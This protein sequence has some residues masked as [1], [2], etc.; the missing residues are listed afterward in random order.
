MLDL[1]LLRFERSLLLTEVSRVICLESLKIQFI[2]VEWTFEWFSFTSVFVKN[3]FQ[4]LN[5]ICVWSG[6]YESCSLI[7]NA[8]NGT[9]TVALSFFIQTLGKILYFDKCLKIV[10]SN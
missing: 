3:I 5:N 4:Q 2:C 10:P 6:K 8:K 9:I 7:K 1:S